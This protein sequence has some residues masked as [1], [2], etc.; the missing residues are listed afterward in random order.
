MSN[1]YKPAEGTV[2]SK[3]VTFLGMIFVGIVAM[4]VVAYTY[5]FDEISTEDLLFLSLF[6]FGTALVLTLAIHKTPLYSMTFII[7]SF[8][9]L[10][11]PAMLFFEGFRFSGLSREEVGYFI[12][13]G[14]F[15]LIISSF[16]YFAGFLIFRPLFNLIFGKK[17]VSQLP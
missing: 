8:L 16:I 6:S 2:T 9:I 14:G 7:I 3:V 15:V 13:G 5:G 12:F 4:S 10:F 11:L 1:L 17:E